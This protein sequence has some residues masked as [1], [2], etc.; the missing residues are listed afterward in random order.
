MKDKQVMGLRG[1][2]SEKFLAKIEKA[3]EKEAQPVMT[4]IAC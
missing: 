4:K 1:V 3:D 2:R